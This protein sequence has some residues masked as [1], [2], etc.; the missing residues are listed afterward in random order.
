MKLKRYLVEKVISYTK[1]IEVEA[2]NAKEAMEIAQDASESEWEED[3]CGFFPYW[4]EKM[5]RP[6]LIKEE[7][8][9]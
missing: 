9:K 5:K 6:K 8:E 1:Y 7:E 3:E 2:E 4:D